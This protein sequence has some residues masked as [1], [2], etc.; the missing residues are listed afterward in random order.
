ME[1]EYKRA[2]P[3]H[4]DFKLLVKHLDEDLGNRYGKAQAGYEAHNII[5]SRA[6]VVLGYE[7]HKPVAC[8]CFRPMHEEGVVEIKRMFTMH[9]YRG[10]GLAKKILLELERWAKE[11]GFKTARLETG[12]NQP[13]AIAV[14]KKSGYSL[15][16]NYGPYV[17]NPNSVCMQKSL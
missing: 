15:I 8:G 5:D 1:L 2:T 11:N 7:A 16:D 9:P 3:V 12:I 13:E 4:E 17:D 14:Y 6:Y 10:N